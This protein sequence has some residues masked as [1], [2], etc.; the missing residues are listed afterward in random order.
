MLKFSKFPCANDFSNLFANKESETISEHQNGGTHPFLIYNFQITHRAIHF[1]LI[2]LKFL[3]SGD[4]IRSF[5]FVREIIV[6]QLC[7]K[8]LDNFLSP[9]LSRESEFDD[10]LCTL[11]TVHIFS[12]C[13]YDHS[14]T[15]I[16]F[17]FR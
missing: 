17:D 15:Y 1:W 6:D 7:A 5:F 2:N 14:G 16:C 3:T 8:L 11:Y 12:I 9:S 4:L 13:S 10:T